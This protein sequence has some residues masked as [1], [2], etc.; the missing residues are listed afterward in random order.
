MAWLAKK[1]SVYIGMINKLT[2]EHCKH[3][4]EDLEDGIL[5]VSLEFDVAIHLC[6]CGCKAKTV[7]PIRDSRGWNY[8]EKEGRPTLTPSIGNF[9][10]ETPYHAHYF[11]T[12]GK[13]RFV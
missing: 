8:S 11:I 5:Y 6:A 7:T 4:P 3:I 9:S 10:G 2:I 12:E 1:R 13:V